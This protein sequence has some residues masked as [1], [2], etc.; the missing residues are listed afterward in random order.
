MTVNVLLVTHTDV[1]SAMMQVVQTTF[2]QMPT[3]W[4]H[5]PVSYQQNAE[6]LLADLTHVLQAL[7]G[8]DGTLVI[9]DV[10]GATPCNTASTLKQQYNIR[11]ISGV[12]LPMLFKM[13]NYAELPL[14][15]LADKALV[16]GREG[17]RLC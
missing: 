12:N 3:H 7:P 13:V 9:T 8:T 17:I 16:G 5:I 2:G 10:F 14:D 4:H 1:G 15:E 11:L 6:S